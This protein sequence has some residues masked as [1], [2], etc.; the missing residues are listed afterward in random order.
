M[1]QPANRFINPD[2]LAT[3][4]GYTHVVETNARRTI[5]ISGQIPLD[6]QGKLVGAG[7]MKAQAEQVFENLRLA[8]EAVHATFADV[9]KLTY[10]VVD[11]S[12]IQVVREVRNRYLNADRLPAS[13]AVEV[14]QL[15]RK[16]FLLEVEAIAALND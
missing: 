4:T 8:L 7:D 5:F 3:P 15:V 10:F 2:T 6:S 12:Q 16:E 14:R 9:I 11:I 13:T 1:S